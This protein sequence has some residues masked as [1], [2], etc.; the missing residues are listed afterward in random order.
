MGV[1]SYLSEQSAEEFT[2]AKKSVS[3]QGSFIMFFSYFAAG[4]V[5]LSPYLL[6]D[7]KAA[8][9]ISILFSLVALFLLGVTSSKIFKSD[10]TTKHGI[11][12][13]VIG[14]LAIA[15]GIIIGKLVNA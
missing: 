8:F 9:V 7:V 15:V 3:L 1:G 6:F 13:L 5:P 10:H 11:K 14:G 12:M 4:F 2:G